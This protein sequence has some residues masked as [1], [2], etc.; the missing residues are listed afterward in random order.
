MNKPTCFGWMKEV[1]CNST[2]ECGLEPLCC[3]KSLQNIH[4]KHKNPPRKVVGR[5]TTKLGQEQKQ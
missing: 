1:G 4:R 3:I 2:D 5:V